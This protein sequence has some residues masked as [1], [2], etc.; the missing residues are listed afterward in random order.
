MTRTEIIYLLPYIAS[1]ILSIGIFLYTWQ[2]RFARGATPFIWYLVGQSLWIAG[3]IFELLTPDLPGKIFWDSFQWLTELLI[4]IAFPAFIVEYTE[5]KIK[6]Q[7]LLFSLSLI[8]PIIFG[9]LVLT[10]S[11][12]HLIHAHAILEP[13]PPFDELGYSFTPVVAVYVIY[14]YLVI[15]AGIA[16]LLKSIFPLNNHYRIQTII[17]MTGLLIPVIGTLSSLAGIRFTSHRDT[18]PFTTAIG[19]LIIVWGLF[20]YQVFEVLPVGRDRVFESI[21]DPVVILNNKNIILDVNRSMLDLLGMQSK[22]VVGKSAKVIFNDFPLPIKLYSQVSYAQVEAA[23]ELRGKTVYYEMTVWPLFNNRKQMTG[24]LYISHDITALKELE[25]ALRELNLDL[26]KRVQARTRELAEAYDTTLE[27]WAKALELR[28]KETEGHS[29]RVM[30]ITMK[31]ANAME[32]SEDELIHIRRGALLH[33]I[34]KMAIPDEILQKRGPLTTDERI[35][36]QSHP[37]IAY[38]LLESIPFLQKA[39]E[40][41]YAH[42]EKWDGSGYPRGLKGKGIPL[43]ARI[44]TVADVWDAL[45]SN[46]PYN[47]EWP[48]D[49]AINYLVEQAGKQFDPRV[50]NIFL[51]LVEKGK[52]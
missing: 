50:V 31:I 32:I 11:L 6:N 48:R 45:L 3:F 9:L 30:E 27:G 38:K 12:H 37:E 43:S 8:V 2:R 17:I 33:D 21:V 4:I 26:E 41:P 1:L 20:R 44:F 29:R 34:G 40:I 28:D 49:K 25:G 46:R 13:A 35:V 18:V 14:S 19:N 42:H 16:L 10:D 23:F 24:R 51:D 22:D 7:K 52:I 36:V 5:Q 15:I 39:I 47:K